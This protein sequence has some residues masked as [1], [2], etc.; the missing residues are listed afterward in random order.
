MI[1]K[2]ALRKRRAQKHLC[3]MTSNSMNDALTRI[4]FL[5][6]E[7]GGMSEYDSDAMD[8]VMPIDN[9]RNTKKTTSAA[10]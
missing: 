4:Q 10:L 9:R 2:L 6:M 3:W 7:E 5:E 1:P 8:K